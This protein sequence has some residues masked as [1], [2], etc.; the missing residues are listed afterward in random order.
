M[1]G[2]VVLLDTGGKQEFIFASNK[3]AVNVGASE[4]IM[5]VGTN[6]VTEAI[7]A[8]AQGR[9]TSDW[10]LV[11][12]SGKAVLTVPDEGTGR[13]IIRAVTTRALR[14]APGLEVSGVV[15]RIETDLGTTIREAHRLHEEVRAGQPSPWL[16]HPTLPYVH[17]CRYTGLPAT[18]R[19]KERDRV[20]PRAA[21]VHA[22]WGM[23]DEARERM[24]S[25]LSQNAVVDAGRLDQGVTHSGWVAVVHADGNGLGE[26]FRS[27]HEVYT[28]E[29]YRDVFGTF[30]RTLDEVTQDAL[31]AAVRT[32]AGRSDWILPIVVGGDDVTAIMDARFAFDVTHT[33]L[34]E[35]EQRSRIDPINAVLQRVWE[36][37]HR[38]EAPPDGLTAAAG[39]AFV[40]PHRAFSDAYRLAEQLCESAKTLKNVDGSRSALDFHVLHDSV[41]RSLDELRGEQVVE[42]NDGTTLRL[43]AG[44]YLVGRP[45]GNP[46]VQLQHVD[47]LMSAMSAQRVTGGQS[48]LLP[49]GTVV[50]LRDALMRS[51]TR[52]LRERDQ[53]I[54]W[55]ARPDEAREHL[56]RHLWVAPDVNVAA[57]EP[58][59]RIIDAARLLDME[60]G[61]VH[62]QPQPRELG[63][64]EQEQTETGGADW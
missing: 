61:T 43:W 47:H 53:V 12:A 41:S 23:R 42:D 11:Q 7:A 37:R 45:A 9:D 21:T 20:F 2:H 40:K 4:L 26:V 48:P 54:S 56:D 5:R 57:N 3:Q 49:V 6:W 55:H 24:A 19:G 60:R 14:E 39:I 46:R 17:P 32:Q 34:V 36:L 38:G 15:L 30:S 35:F 22:A 16:R 27:L 50:R 33:F 28:D 13:S 59:T 10:V 64:D 62:G 52:A 18:A 1:T 29:E 63:N 44:P 25:H 51:R 58:F 31:K 8:A